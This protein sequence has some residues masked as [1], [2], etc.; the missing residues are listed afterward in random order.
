VD[1]A[2]ARYQSVIQA[3]SKVGNPQG[4]QNDPKIA[5]CGL[6]PAGFGTHANQD[7]PIPN[8]KERGGHLLVVLVRQKTDSQPPFWRVYG[9]EAR[10]ASTAEKD[11]EDHG[12][13][14]GQRMMT[15]G[16]HLVS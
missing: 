10:A 5:C 3:E 2:A 9:L 7:P 16:H 12:E 1:T 6:P 4:P 8:Q 14:K 13:E 15:E 11:Q